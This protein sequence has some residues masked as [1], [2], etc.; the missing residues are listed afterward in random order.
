MPMNLVL[1]DIWQFGVTLNNHL[2]D[3]TLTEQLVLGMALEMCLQEE[4]TLSS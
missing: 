3:L 1:I 2:N 4:V